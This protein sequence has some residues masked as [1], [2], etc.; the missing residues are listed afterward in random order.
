MREKSLLRF[1]EAAYSFK[2][3]LDG[4]IDSLRNDGREPPFASRGNLAAFCSANPGMELNGRGHGYTVRT[5]DYSYYFRCL[6]RLGDYD[7]YCFAYDNR[8]LLSE[9]AGKQSEAVV[10]ETV[11]YGASGMSRI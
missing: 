1:S 3:E 5:L 11:V 4:V 9:L 2:Q 8:Y 6:P 10:P 7:V